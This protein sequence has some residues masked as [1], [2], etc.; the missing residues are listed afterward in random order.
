MKTFLKLIT[1][2]VLALTSS[3]EIDESLTDEELIA[4]GYKIAPILSE[5]E[6]AEIAHLFPPNPD[7]ALVERIQGIMDRHYKNGSTSIMDV[8]HSHQVKGLTY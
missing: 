1:I 6:F 5:E 4:Q 2:P 3:A 8:T 7:P